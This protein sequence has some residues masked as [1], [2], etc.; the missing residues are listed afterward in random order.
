MSKKDFYHDLVKEALIK[1]GW[2]IVKEQM[3]LNAGKRKLFVDLSADLIIAE[4]ADKK[5]AVEIKSFLNPSEISDF[6]E[7]LGQFNL[8]KVALAEQEPDRVLYLAIPEWAYTELFEDVFMQKILKVYEIQL[9]L[10]DTQNIENLKW[11]NI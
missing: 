3:L 2:T 5:I 11:I 7:A 10:F 9:I 6:Q 1:A 4:K 8:Y